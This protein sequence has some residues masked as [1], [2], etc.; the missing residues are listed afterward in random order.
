MCKKLMFIS[1]LRIIVLIIV[2]ANSEVSQLIRV[3][4]VGHN[5]DP[6]AQTV[7]L[8]VLLGQI[9]EVG[10]GEVHI[11]ADVQLH[12]GPLER[13]IVAQVVH[14]AVDLKSS[15]HVFLL[16]GSKTDTQIRKRDR[17]RAFTIRIYSSQ[18]IYIYLSLSLL[19]PKVNRLFRQ[20]AQIKKSD[21]F[22]N[23]PL[24]TLPSERHAIMLSLSNGKSAWP[25]DVQQY[26]YMGI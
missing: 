8:Q 23:M 13:D 26:K 5:T 18:Y 14:F 19:R 12:L 22:F 16:R 15:L 7:L 10:L 24:S 3:L 20:K 21:Q 17:D 9:L 11:G 25:T 1:L 6:I 4:L 2:G